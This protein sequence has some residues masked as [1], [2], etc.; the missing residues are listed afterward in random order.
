MK[1]PTRLAQLAMACLVGAAQAAPTAANLF[2]TCPFG[3]PTRDVLQRPIAASLWRDG[4]VLAVFWSLDCAFCHRHNER[5]N[6]LLQA[7]PGAPVLGIA[8]DGSA[9]AIQA[10]VKKRGYTFPVITDNCGLRVQLTPRK[11]VP[12]TCWL[13]EPPSKPH[14]IPGEMTDDDLREL[15]RHSHG[16]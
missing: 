8:V 10:T 13:G 2:A 7:E 16:G 4:P 15:L 3:A 11:L 14:C 6:R 9:A 1:A 12:M 5:L